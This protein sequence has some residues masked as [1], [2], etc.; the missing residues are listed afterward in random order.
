M[1]NLDDLAKEAAAWQAGSNGDQSLAGRDAAAHH[2]VAQKLAFAL[3]LAACVFAGVVTWGNLVPSN[4]SDTCCY[5]DPLWLALLLWNLSPYAF[6]SGAAIRAMGKRRLR[7]SLVVLA[8]TSLIAAWGTYANWWAFE[9]RVHLGDVV[10]MFFLPLAQW[11]GCGML[12]L[13][14]RLLRPLKEHIT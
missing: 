14:A 3:T 9:P 1:D 8:G 7:F 12:V 10:V 11:V 6:L 13:L 2:P 4:N 5:A